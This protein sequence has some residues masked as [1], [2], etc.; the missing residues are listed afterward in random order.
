MSLDPVALVR[1][2][3]ESNGSG[4]T[5]GGVFFFFLHSKD[6]PIWKN[7]RGRAFYLVNQLVECVK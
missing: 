3:A 6:I 4:R 7:L 2:C 5:S 1:E